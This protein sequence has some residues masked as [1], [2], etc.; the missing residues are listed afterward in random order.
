MSCSNTITK[1]EKTP[2]TPIPSSLTAQC[3][4]SPPPSE[5]LTWG[6]ALQWDELLLTDLQNC[7]A[8]LAGIRKIELERQN[9]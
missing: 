4:I 8:Q 3:Q 9:E 5:Q 2:V 6:D 7:N 1:Y